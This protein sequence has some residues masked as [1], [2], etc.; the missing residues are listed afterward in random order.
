M[1]IRGGE[2]EKSKLAR[3]TPKHAAPSS[4]QRA[5]SE[6]TASGAHSLSLRV[7]LPLD[8]KNLLEG[9]DGRGRGRTRAGTDEG[10]DDEGGDRRDVF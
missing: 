10:G 7:L 9:G 2:A 4:L 1:E 6:T 8:Q 5:L 3:L